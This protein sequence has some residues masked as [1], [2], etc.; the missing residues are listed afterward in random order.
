MDANAVDF[1]IIRF[2]HGVNLFAQLQQVHSHFSS[3]HFLSL[4]S[5][6]F[7]LAY[8]D[9]KSFTRH[10]AAKITAAIALCSA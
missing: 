10:R 5:D 9:L 8:S 4:R 2:G 3:R 1:V 6:S 7:R